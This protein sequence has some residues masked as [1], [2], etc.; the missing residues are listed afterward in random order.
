MSLLVQ[1][2][3]PNL[4]KIA[5]PYKLPMRPLLGVG[6]STIV[7]YG[8]VEFKKCMVQVQDFR[9]ITDL[10]RIFYAM[11]S[12]LCDATLCDVAPYLVS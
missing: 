3:N 7:T 9:K 5:V 10:F 11:H 4:I 6:A 2:Y 1:K 12:N 8:L